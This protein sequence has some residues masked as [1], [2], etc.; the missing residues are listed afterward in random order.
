MAKKQGPAGL[1]G[2]PIPA[3]DEIGAAELAGRV[4]ENL[5]A[6]RKRRAMS[7]DELAQLTGVSRAALSQIETRKT[8]PTISVLWKIASGLGIAFAD[9]IG[10]TRAELSVLRRG[11]AQ[12]LR[13]V[14]GKF[15]SRPSKDSKSGRSRSQIPVSN[16]PLP[17]HLPNAASEKQQ[18]PIEYRG[19]IR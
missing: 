16:V 12:P 14:D 4:A 18:L 9:L 17:A 6:Q 3:G 10:E 5:R 11:E 8:N 13:S 19:M 2:A 1:R 15:E 7:L